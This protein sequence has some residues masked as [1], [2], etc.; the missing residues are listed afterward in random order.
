[1]KDWS[2]ER[3]RKLYLREALEQRLWSVM[4]RGLRDYLIRLAEDDG[5]LIRDAEDPVDALLTVLGAHEGEAELVRGAIE[6][7]RRD[8]FLGGG[9]RA[10]LVRNLPVAQSW[11]AR[12]P[13]M[14]SAREV[15]ADVPSQSTSAERVRRYRE[16]L[17][18]AAS[19]ALAAVTGN[20]A[21]AV[22]CNAEPVTSGVTNGVTS[23]VTGN[24]SS[25]VTASRGSGNLNPSGSFLDLQQDK[26]RDLLPSS[27]RASAVTSTVTGNVSSSV[28][29][30]Y[31]GDEEEDEEHL[32]VPRS[33]EE[34][35]KIGVAARAALVMNQPAL[36][37]VTQPEQWPEVISVA[38]V[39][40]RS[41][42]VGEQRMGRYQRDP[43]VRAL[44]ELYAA[45]FT[46]L[47][48]ERVAQVVPRQSWWSAQGKR[49]GLSSLSIEVVR[50][51][52]PGTG[53]PREISPQVAKVLEAVRQ[54]R[55]AG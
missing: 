5:A 46:Q 43:G 55:E 11:E 3:W 24:V 33:R 22:S 54:R 8:G 13:V 35:L 39:F 38:S 28:T 15:A 16:R 48:L 44:V 51:N 29:S 45:G 41:A 47:E 50:R 36:A 25:G 14:A 6:L 2:K 31:T 23:T 21:D 32:Q 9:A 26:Q 37:G 7:L 4:A 20:A 18:L 30:R 27:E 34:A 17:R 19:G 1:M 10:L 12:T 53:P 52:L 40:A 42:G 49:L